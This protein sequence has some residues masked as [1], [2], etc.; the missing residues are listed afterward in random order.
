MNSKNFI[1]LVNSN[2][3]SINKDFPLNYYPRPFVTLITTNNTEC[4]KCLIDT[5]ASTSCISER[6]LANIPSE[7]IVKRDESNTTTILR[8]AGGSI[9][10]IAGKI[11]L[12]FKLMNKTITHSFHIIRNLVSDG[13]LGSDFINQQRVL[14]WGTGLNTR[15]AFIS[16]LLKPG[17]ITDVMKDELKK[18]DQNSPRKTENNHSDKGIS[19]INK[20]TVNIPANSVQLITVSRILYLNIP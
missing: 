17:V 6:A 9:L 3:K 12:L 1:G 4:L 20:E 16:D 15:V 14:V 13:I 10:H 5:G 11:T 19:F 2:I 18:T 7:S 8:G